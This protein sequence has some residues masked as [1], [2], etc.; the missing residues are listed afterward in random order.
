M[1]D[2]DRYWKSD[3][4]PTGAEIR[5][6]DFYFR[7]DFISPVW[8]AF[9]EYPF[10]L[11]LKF[12]FSGIIEEFFSKTG[13]PYIQTTL[14]VWR[15]LHWISLLNENKGMNVGLEEIASVYDIKPLRSFWF[16]LKRKPGRTPL[17]EDFSQEDGLWKERFFLVK[18]STI[19]LGET[20]PM[21]WIQESLSV[22]W[23]FPFSFSSFNFMFSCFLAPKFG[24]IAPASSDTMLKVQQFLALPLLDRTFSLQPFSFSND[25]SSDNSADG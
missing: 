8:V 13:I 15:I 9:P 7:P 22:L 3:I 6:C 16:V 5:G 25:S 10:L 23:Q 18:R 17:V 14:G 20:L 1:E 12:P 24:D 2:I 4:F 11:G 21:E 19:P